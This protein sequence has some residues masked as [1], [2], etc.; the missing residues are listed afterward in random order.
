VDN[1]TQASRDRE[2]RQILEAE[3]RRAEQQVLRLLGEPAQDSPSMQA[4]LA[5]ARSDVQALR[6]ELARLSAP[7]SSTAPAGPGASSAP[8]LPSTTLTQ[9]PS[10]PFSPARSGR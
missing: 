9:A 6:S 1:T 3:L 2:A 8:M 10:S 7:A 4:A 5:R